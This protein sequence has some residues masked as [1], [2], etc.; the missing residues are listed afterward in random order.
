ME[1]WMFA[2]AFAILVVGSAVQGVAGFGANLLASPLLVLLDPALVPGPLIVAAVPLVILTALANRGEHPWRKLRWANVGQVMGAALGAWVLASLPTDGITIF[3]AVVILGAV[4]LSASGVTVRR[5]PRTM[6]AAGALSAFTGTSVGIGGPPIALVHAGE[7]GEALRAA[8]SRFFITG[9][10]L[11]LVALTIVGRF[12]P[13][14]AA[15]GLLLVTGTLVGFAISRRLVGRLDRHHL[16][17]LILVLSG[18]SAVAALLRA[19]L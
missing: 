5:T 7:P 9:V 2:A 17:V 16:R 4:A 15:A 6:A 14:D 13:A 3:F 11:S 1:P 12:R 8:L 18:A 19:L 10:A